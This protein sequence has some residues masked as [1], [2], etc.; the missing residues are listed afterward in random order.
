[1]AQNQI[2]QKNIMKKLG[3][4]VLNPSSRR[5]LGCLHGLT[6]NSKEE[7]KK[8]E[9]IF[10]P[11]LPKTKRHEKRQFYSSLQNLKL[12]TSENG[13]QSIDLNQVKINP[14]EDD[15]VKMRKYKEFMNL[16]LTD[17]I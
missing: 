14:F 2:T 17:K 15:R 1:M 6:S 5:D 9:K 4:F 3:K 12:I 10:L 7:I 11:S 13:E 8:I 16:K